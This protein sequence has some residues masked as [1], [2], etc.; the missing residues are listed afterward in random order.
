[1]K[2]VEDPRV[3]ENENNFQKAW[4][5]YWHQETTKSRPEK[6]MGHYVFM[7]SICL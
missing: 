5:R 6:A 2:K 1:M 7:C 4:D 3:T